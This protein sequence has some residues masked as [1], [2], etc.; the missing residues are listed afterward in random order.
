M[1]AK[2][3]EGIIRRRVLDALTRYRDDEEPH[4]VPSPS[5]IADCFRKQVMNRRGIPKSN[6]DKPAWFKKQEQGK[7]VEP[8]WHE[9]FDRAEFDVADLTNTERI[10]IAGGPMTGIGDRL[11]RDRLDEI[12]FQIPMLLELK[13]LGMFTFFSF[14]QK[15][16]RE[17]LPYYYYQVQGYMEAYD[18]PLAVV[19]AGQADASACTFWWRTRMTCTRTGKR[20][21]HDHTCADKYHGDE[22][23]WPDPFVVEVVQR[24]PADFAWAQQRA[25]DVV[26]YADNPIPLKDVPRDYD[27]AY[28]KWKGKTS[29]CTYC[30]QKDNCLEAGE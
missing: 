20:K 7:L 24:A 3:A 6:P 9:V 2:T 18:V 22:Q 10:L 15:G 16:L 4:D 23:I 1:D 17:G 29:P 5:G 28:E 21:Q 26:Y 8:F 13:D 27:P 25:K 12:P 30:P 11:L 14:M 19:F